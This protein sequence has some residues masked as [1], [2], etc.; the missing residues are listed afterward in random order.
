MA[1]DEENG[2]YKKTTHRSGSFLKKNE[3]RLFEVGYLAKV[4][5]AVVK[6]LAAHTPD[7]CVVVGSGCRMAT[8]ASALVTYCIKTLISMPLAPGGTEIICERVT[9]LIGAD[10][11]EVTVHNIRQRSAGCANSES[12]A[13]L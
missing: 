8:T 5:V 10:G 6:I 1:G 4:L 11:N 12:D 9:E 2:T 7:E 13:A 3:C